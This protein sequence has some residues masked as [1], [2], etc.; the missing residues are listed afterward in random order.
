MPISTADDPK[1]DQAR[2]SSNL[3]L[4]RPALCASDCTL[5]TPESHKMSVMAP[6][7]VFVSYVQEN[8]EIVALLVRELQNRD[9]DPWW[10]RDSLLPGAFWQDEIRRAIRDGQF[11]LACFSSDYLARDITFMN[12]ELTIAIEEIRLRG[13]STWFIPV[14]LSGEV[15]NRAIGGGRTLRHIQFVNLAPEHWSE[16][17]AAL[18]NV[19]GQVRTPDLPATSSVLAHQRVETDAESASDLH[20]LAGVGQHASDFFE[21]SPGLWKVSLSHRGGGHFAVWLLDSEGERVELLVN[22]TGTF[23][24][25]KLVKIPR[26]GRFLYDV[27]AD[28]PWDILAQPPMELEQMAHIR[29]GSQAGTDL[30]RFNGGLRV[31]NLQH[32]GV[33]HFAVWLLD[34]DGEHVELLVNAT[35]SFDGSKAVKLRSGV[36]AFDVSADGAWNITWR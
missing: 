7:R 14:L 19:M 12:E 5:R 35:G 25:T 10:D 30:I 9:I 3:R 18:C 16:G 27:S 29:G 8:R 34:R 2:G 23:H 6:L 36:Y 32:E 17:I 26:E 21:L 31:F 24:G 4:G 22:A 33:G 11:F 1:R 20:R 15:P 28:G 13:D